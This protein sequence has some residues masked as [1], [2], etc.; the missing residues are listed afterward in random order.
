MFALLIQGFGYAIARVITTQ[1]RNIAYLHI[2]LTHVIITNHCW[3]IQSPPSKEVAFSLGKGSFFPPWKNYIL[4]I[5]SIKE[6]TF[7]I[8]SLHYIFYTPSSIIN[9]SPPSHSPPWATT[10]DPSQILLLPLFVLFIVNLIS[11]KW[12]KK[13]ESLTYH[14]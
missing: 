3:W 1:L 9:L 10:W 12:N 14:K 8:V 7:I 2:F 6:H 5:K 11:W 4:T 13:H